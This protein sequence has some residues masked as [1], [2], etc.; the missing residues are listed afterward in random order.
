M[1]DKPLWGKGPNEIPYG[2]HHRA[3]NR[4]IKRIMKRPRQAGNK[5]PKEPGKLC[6]TI[7]PFAAVPALSSLA[8]AIIQSLRG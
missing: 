8:I 5:P 7:A 6:I 4:S 3:R 2:Q 1:P